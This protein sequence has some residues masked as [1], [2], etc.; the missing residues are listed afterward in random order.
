MNTPAD[1]LTLANAI[2]AACDAFESAWRDGQQPS[3]EKFLSDVPAEH[4]SKYLQELLAIEIH[5]MS[6]L[7]F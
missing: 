1:N 6:R 5:P 2:D 7:A 3:V 4:R